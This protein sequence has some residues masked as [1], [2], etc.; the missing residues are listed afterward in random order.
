MPSGTCYLIFMKFKPTYDSN[1]DTFRVEFLLGPCVI[2]ALVLN[3]SFA[4]TE[5][6]QGTFLAF[7]L[8]NIWIRVLVMCL[9]AALS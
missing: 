1:H 7:S 6:I 8:L 3:H 5:V 2:L 9:R 4:V